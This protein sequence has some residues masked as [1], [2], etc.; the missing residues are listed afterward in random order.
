[1]RHTVTTLSVLQLLIEQKLLI[2]YIDVVTLVKM[3]TELLSFY[4][5]EFMLKTTAYS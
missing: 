1:M 3:E 4:Y 5:N 2:S